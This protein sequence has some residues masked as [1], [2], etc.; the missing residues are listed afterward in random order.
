MKAPSRGF[1][2]LSE[3]WLQTLFLLIFLFIGY[4]V[5]D[6]GVF[7]A[8]MLSRSEYLVLI[9]VGGALGQ[10]AFFSIWIA[11]APDAFWRRTAIAAAMCVVLYNAMGLTAAAVEPNGMRDFDRFLRTNLVIPLVLISSATPFW[12]GGVVLGWRLV[13]PDAPGGRGQRRFGIGQ[14]MIATAVLGVAMTLTRFGLTENSAVNNAEPT[15][16][17]IA[18]SICATVVAF[19]VL[20]AAPC[21]MLVMLQHTSGSL[22]ILLG[23]FGVLIASCVGLMVMTGGFRQIGLG[24]LCLMLSASIH[25][26]CSLLLLRFGNVELE[27]QAEEDEGESPFESGVGS[28]PF[29]PTMA[30]AENMEENPNLFQ[31]PESAGKPHPLD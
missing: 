1:T 7:A 12:L 4:G 17:L 31:P 20:V 13:A 21:M 28:S 11:L 25:L 8:A 23:Y 18:F 10:L 16:F 6:C 22:A 30:A 14:V 24:L 2:T 29:Q 9:A 15:W 5:I 19:I 3:N 27:V 26:S